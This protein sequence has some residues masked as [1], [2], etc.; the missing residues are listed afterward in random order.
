[1]KRDFIKPLIIMTPKSLLRSEQACS[2]VEEFLQGRFSEI[3]PAPEVAPAEKIER[4]ILCSGKVYYDLL[5]HRQEEQ[6]TN[7]QIVRLEQLYPLAEEKLRA[8]LQSFKSAQ[9]IVWCQE[10]SQNMGAWSFIEPRLRA[11]LGREILYAGRN[12]SA[13]PAVG[14]LAI[15]KREQACVINEAF[16]V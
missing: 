7:V 16:S 8:T 14:A 12:A 11:L 1:M 4:V 3:L 10:E 15:H 6:L 2:R 13:S 5:N 9:K